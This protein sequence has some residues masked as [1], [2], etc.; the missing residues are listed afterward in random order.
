MVEPAGGSIL[1]HCHV[2]SILVVPVSHGPDFHNCFSALLIPFV[3][4]GATAGQIL[5]PSLIQAVILQCLEGQAE[6]QKL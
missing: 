3:R 4:K 1:Y 2:V 5:S 6:C